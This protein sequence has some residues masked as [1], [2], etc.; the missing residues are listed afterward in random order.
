MVSRAVAKYLRISPRKF[1][2]IIPLVK[3][4]PVEEAIALLGGVGKKASGYAIDILTSAMNNAK[5]K[6]EDIDIGKLFVS[7]FTADCGPTNRRFR[8]ASMGRAVTIRKRTSH[9]TVE[10]DEIKALPGRKKRVKKNDGKEK[11]VKGES[12]TT[13][14]K[15][16]PRGYLPT[17]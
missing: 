6:E 12:K 8:A 3:N 11:V 10:L 7:K 2:Q 15:R 4:R 1:R 16:N 17:R 9:V 13:L 14:K 5:N